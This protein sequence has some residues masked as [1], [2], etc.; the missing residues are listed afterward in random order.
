MRCFRGHLLGLFVTLLPG[1]AGCIE[2]TKSSQEQDIE[3]FE[4]RYRVS[5]DFAVKL[6]PQAY[7]FSQNW[8][9]QRV[10]LDPAAAATV[11]TLIQVAMSADARLAELVDGSN[12]RRFCNRVEDTLENRLGS[13]SGRFWYANLSFNS[14]H[15]L[16]SLAPLSD[17]EVVSLEFQNFSL[18]NLEALEEIET[19]KELRIIHPNSDS[20]LR[21][22]ERGFGRLKSL[23]VVLQDGLALRGDVRRWLRNLTK[24][25]EFNFRSIEDDGVELEGIEQELSRLSL[26]S[27][28]LPRHRF[29]SFEWVDFSSIRRLVV[30]FSA[31]DQPNFWIHEIS[32]SPRLR[33]LELH[34]T[35]WTPL[36]SI[37]SLVELRSLS[38]VGLSTI[39][40][41]FISKLADLEY[42]TLVW[43]LDTLA[44]QDVDRIR[45]QIK[46]LPRLQIFKSNLQ[47]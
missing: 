11:E 21:P 25:N 1:L 31:V 29:Q 4:L 30:S 9:Q 13:R 40:L 2:S 17:L 8:C 20:N 28:S 39:D 34:N 41:D 12:Q 6:P 7:D 18:V 23:T 43:R 44:E 15:S 47:M 22:L 37:S 45:E 42:L 5:F 32:K 27:V 19:L 16:K 24:L 36:D 33:H 10:G 3:D 14:T 38:L 35:G 26:K 46:G